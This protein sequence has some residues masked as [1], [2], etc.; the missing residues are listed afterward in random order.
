MSL[1][2]VIALLEVL[3][4]TMD[5]AIKNASPDWGGGF[6]RNT[7]LDKCRSDVTIFKKIAQSKK[8]CTDW[9]CPRK[10][11]RSYFYR[12]VKRCCQDKDRHYVGTRK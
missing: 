9:L 10:C 11:H 5:Q 6:P 4:M 8:G 12:D 1:E 7:F 2:H 3:E